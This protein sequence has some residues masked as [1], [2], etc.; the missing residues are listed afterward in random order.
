MAARAVLIAYVNESAAEY[1]ATRRER[2]AHHGHGDRAF[3]FEKADTMEEVAAW[4]I[5]GTQLCARS[6]VWAAWVQGIG[7]VAAIVA[8]VWIAWWQRR[9]DHR[10]SD[11]RARE[12]TYRAI[13][14]GMF[15]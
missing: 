13:Q 14:V 4:C 11:L 7:S 2:K 3:G 15:Y 9:Q 1:E 6:E 5:S 10:R 8:A 12:E